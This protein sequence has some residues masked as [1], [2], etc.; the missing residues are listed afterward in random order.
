MNEKS[1][2]KSL[3]Q[4]RKDGGCGMWNYV[5]I[6]NMVKIGKYSD[7]YDDEKTKFWNGVKDG[8]WNEKGERI[9]NPKSNKNKEN[10]NGK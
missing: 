8:R 3:H 6:P 1:I 5:G 10:T 9:S 7:L 4:K 2:K